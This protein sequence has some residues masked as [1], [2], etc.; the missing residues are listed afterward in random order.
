MGEY[1]ALSPLEIEI[2]S[3]QLAGIRP[4]TG[5]EGRVPSLELLEWL[6]A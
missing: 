2:I 4:S 5:L 6:T 1:P 3:L